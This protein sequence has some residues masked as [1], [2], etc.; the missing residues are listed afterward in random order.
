MIEIIPNWHPIFVHFTVALL[1]LVGVIQLILFV[2]KELKLKESLFAAQN[3]MIGFGVLA[4]L[5]TIATGLQAYYSVNHDGPS[6]VAMTDHR[7]WALL[8]GGIFVLCAALFSMKSA[9]LKN[10]A[11]YG[12]VLVTALVSVTAF[13]GGE[14]V[15]RHGL[16]VMSLPEVSGEGH[17]HEH[18]D[19]HEHA[20]TVTTHPASVEEAHDSSPDHHAK[21]DPVS[22]DDSTG[23]SEH[24]HEDGGHEHADEQTDSHTDGHDHSTHSHAHE[25]KPESHS[26]SKKPTMFTGQETEAGQAV[27]A[28]HKALESGD[29]DRVKSLL[30][31]NVLIFEGG[32]VERSA[33]EYASHHMISDM[34]FLKAIDKQLL[35]Q[36]VHVYGDSAV[37]IS[38]NQFSGVYKDKAVD[39]QSME[40]LSLQRK[41]GEWKITHIHWSN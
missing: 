12:F 5:A 32:G 10:I 25:A 27:Q 6:H 28:F 24:S 41:N 23:V 31:P 3:W 21:N 29:V 4:T 7:N 39:V 8:T 34:A 1:F 40:T 18:A 33:S 13:K 19:G 38:R 2:T 20:H 22:H 26:H 35:E 36:K 17:D 9:A 16:G 37:S 11:T 30:D 15:Y 14:I